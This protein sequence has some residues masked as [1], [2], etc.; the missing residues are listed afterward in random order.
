MEENDSGKIIG[1][2]SFSSFTGKLGSGGYLSDRG[3]SY[4]H[5]GTILGGAGL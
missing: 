1:L 4:E 5:T 3:E 2:I